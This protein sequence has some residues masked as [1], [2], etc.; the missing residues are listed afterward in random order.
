MRDVMPVGVERRK[1]CSDIRI[2]SIRLRPTQ[3]QVGR[4]D[5]ARHAHLKRL[6]L[7]GGRALLP[8]DSA[9][10]GAQR[11]LRRHC[12]RSLPPHTRFAR[13]IAPHLR[14]S[15][16]QPPRFSLRGYSLN[17]SGIVASFSKP[18]SA[19]HESAMRVRPLFC[20]FRTE[21]HGDRVSEWACRMGHQGRRTTLRVR[22]LSASS[23]AS[24]I[25]S[26]S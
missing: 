14:P 1:A 23:T 12:L 6:W 24:L 15:L 10:I 2:H 25:R 13:C 20:P 8:R 4:Q 7:G 26:R 17:V 22:P 19:M 3:R 11:P 16:P 5:G 9:V 18:F 21:V